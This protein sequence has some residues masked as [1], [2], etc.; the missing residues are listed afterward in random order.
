MPIRPE[1]AEPLSTLAFLR[2]CSRF[3][4]I[5][6]PHA[7]REQLPDQGFE[8]RFRE[9]CVQN[10]EGWVISEPREFQLGS[11]LD[12][13]SGV[14]HEIDIVARR[15]NATAILEAKNLGDMPG[16]NDIVVFFAK[17]LDYLLAN[18]ELAM[19]DLCLVFL[20]RN[21]FESSAMAACIGLGIHP[22]ASDIR[23]LPVLVDNAIRMESE[24][25]KGLVVPSE[26]NDRFEDWCALLNHLGFILNNTWP[27]NRFGYLSEDS[28]LVKAVPLQQTDALAQRLRQAN[29]DCID[30][31]NTFR[32]ASASR[33]VG[34]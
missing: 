4:S 7:E 16:K 30:L 29:G 13:A 22:V 1:I 25:H 3:V 32:S 15:S 28:L 8:Q 5:E 10:L 17:I 2:R 12:T 14:A 9:S 24:L 18:P 6:W 26:V 31:L 11:G 27:D 21:S 19:N 34:Q 23:P 33:G 20:S